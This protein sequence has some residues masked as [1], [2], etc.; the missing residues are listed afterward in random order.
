MFYFNRTFVCRCILVHARGRLAGPQFWRRI[1]VLRPLVDSSRPVL[2]CAFDETEYCTFSW[3]MYS[4]AFNCF[5]RTLMPIHIKSKTWRQSRRQL[6]WNCVTVTFSTSYIVTI[7]FPERFFFSTM[8]NDARNILVRFSYFF[9]RLSMWRKV[10]SRTEVEV[11]YDEHH[12]SPPWALSWARWIH[13]TSSHHIPLRST[14]VLFSH[15]FLVYGMFS[16]VVAVL[17]V[18]SSSLGS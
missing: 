17:T 10:L 11:H 2:S 9:S 16:D 5:S 18:G 3:V 7:W 15:L 4:H 12:I 14:L 8:C 6:H 1:P 13:Y